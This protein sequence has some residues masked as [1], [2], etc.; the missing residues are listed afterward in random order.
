[1]LTKLPLTVPVLRRNSMLVRKEQ[2][3]SL[4]PTAIFL[5]LRA[6]IGSGD[7]IVGDANRPQRRRGSLKC[8]QIEPPTIRLRILVRMHRTRCMDMGFPSMPLGAAINDFQNVILH[9][10]TFKETY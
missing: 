1:M 10:R 3:A 4:E 6:L 7:T 9:G 2:I 5:R 8:L